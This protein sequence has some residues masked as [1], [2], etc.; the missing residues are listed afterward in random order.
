MD[1]THLDIER[2]VR[3]VIARLQQEAT[4][5]PVASGS[6]GAGQT[7]ESRAGVRQ[8]DTIRCDQRVVTLATLDGKL[9]GVRRF[10]ARRGAVIT[11][12]VKDLFRDHGIAWSHDG[13]G[14]ANGETR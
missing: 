5:P 3:E 11:P 6:A 10:I 12:A 13:D 2:I 14:S 7:N 4:S 1:L 9:D 8:G